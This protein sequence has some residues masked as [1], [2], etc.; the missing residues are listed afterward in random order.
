MISVNVYVSGRRIS[1]LL[2]GHENP[3]LPGRRPGYVAESAKLPSNL[4]KLG[5]AIR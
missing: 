4:G 1:C 2:L 5:K 3:A